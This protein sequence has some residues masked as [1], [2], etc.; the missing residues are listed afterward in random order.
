MRDF[1][2]IL[3]TSQLV[4]RLCRERE[5]MEWDDAKTSESASISPVMPP[6]QRNQLTP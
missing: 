5:A 6:R 1:P 2:E 4:G 3:G